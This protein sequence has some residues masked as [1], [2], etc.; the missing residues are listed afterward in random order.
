MIAEVQNGEKPR[1]LFLRCNTDGLPPF[2]RI[3]M[4]EQRRCL[5]Q[6]FHVHVKE[7][8]CDYDRMCDL[9]QPDLAMFE[10][11]VYARPRF[12]E[13]ARTHPEVSKIGFLHA[14]AFCPTRSDFLSDMG[15][16]DISTFFTMS[17]SMAGYLPDIADTLFT[18]PN[19]VDPEICRDYGEP[20]PISIL[21][22]GSQVS[23][24]PWRKR[25]H[26][27][28]SDR[29]Q[30]TT[31]P[32]HG[33]RDPW[34]TAAM[35]RGEAYARMINSAVVAPACGTFA[36]DLVRKHLEI[37][38]CGTLLLTQSTPV[39]HA[40]GF[41]DMVNCIF[42]DVADAS[43]K[44]AHLLSRPGELRRV[45]Q[46][47]C[48]LVHTSHTI[49]QRD[50]ILQWFKL[51]RSLR[52]G[53]RIVQTDPFSSFTVET[54][55]SG[56]TNHQLPVVG[57]DRLLLKQAIEAL[58]GH[59]AVQAGKHSRAALNYYPLMP[60]ARLCLALSYLH[61]GQ[62][63]Q[64]LD[65]LVDSVI[66]L[67]ARCGS[68]E[69]DPVEWTYV[70]VA[71]LCRG[72]ISAARQCA[73]QYPDLLH[74][75]LEACRAFLSNLY[76][77]V[78]QTGGHGQQPRASVHLLPR[79]E[80]S[81]WI[82]DLVAMLKACGQQDFARTVSEAAQEVTAPKLVGP[83][84]AQRDNVPSVAFW[85]VPGLLRY[86]L[87]WLAR[88]KVLK[89]IHKPNPI[90]R[91]L[92]SCLRWTRFA[93]QKQ[94]DRLMTWGAEHGAARHHRVLPCATRLVEADRSYRDLYTLAE[95]ENVSSILL[96]A[97]HEPSISSYAL[98]QGMGRSQAFPTIVSLPLD[99]NMER[100]GDAESE[101]LKE[102]M[103]RV[104]VQRFD[105]I[106]VDGTLPQ[107]WIGADEMI[108]ARLV[109]VADTNTFTNHMV[110]RRLVEAGTHRVVVAEPAHLHGYAMLRAV[111]P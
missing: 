21:F 57:R 15:R 102:H 31:S 53:Q 8:D 100:G 96:L 109:W 1:L 43:Y 14:D 62:P 105:L 39:L 87:R 63:G 76:G 79:R 104:G 58:S 65:L 108:N 92:L 61:G 17:T 72:D 66:S 11:G 77:E 25:V 19:F 4:E 101:G 93:G 106:V 64:A 84:P 46:A 97:G 18:W 23:I 103:R 5:A 99:G 32:H 30:V 83:P 33:W 16:W 13:N 3:H 81:V 2:V 10:S 44:V 50:Q 73:R 86:R 88:V 71:L 42:V 90:S 94:I 26:Q 107:G 111:D 34:Q 70:I 67:T 37:P 45:T 55:A 12:I 78:Y 98:K 27:V 28:L 35:P 49:H 38:A 7:G 110:V 68:P 59:D 54:C 41:R 52:T 36:G 95:Q 48:D 20:K 85:P 89:L 29:F 75:E 47:G 69:P 51:H 6:F 9:V 91:R 74:H 24:Y 56:R 40:A 60:E 82:S 22:T 80:P